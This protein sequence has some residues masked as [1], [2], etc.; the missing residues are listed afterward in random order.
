MK[1]NSIRSVVLAALA[2]TGLTMSSFAAGPGGDA[3][4]GEVTYETLGEALA[5]VQANQ[6]VVLQRDCT[7]TTPF[8]NANAGVTL[9]FNGNMVTYGGAGYAFVTTGEGAC[10]TISNGSF[11]AT[12]D[13]YFFRCEN[14]SQ[15]VL[16]G[17]TAD[18]KSDAS[19]I[20]SGYNLRNGLIANCTIGGTQA[21]SRNAVT[22]S[23]DK[24]FS[25][26]YNSVTI[27][28][29]KI[30]VPGTVEEPARWDWNDF[31]PSAA[32]MFGGVRLTITGDATEIRGPVH[33]IYA[34]YNGGE[35][36]IEGG[37]FSAAA[38]FYA[39][40]A[41]DHASN[42]KGWKQIKATITGGE[43]TGRIFT[44]D[45][46]SLNIE[47]G[48]F[49]SFQGWN[50][51]VYNG[52]KTKLSITGGTFDGDPN[53]FA[54]VD[55]GD[56]NKTALNPKPNPGSLNG[57]PLAMVAT[58]TNK[59]GVLTSDDPET[60]EIVEAA[61]VKAVAGANS[62]LTKLEVDGETIYDT[63]NPVDGRIYPYSE[64][65]MVVEGFVPV[66]M[67]VVVDTEMAATYTAGDG[68]HFGEWAGEDSETTQTKSGTA[69][70]DEILD[71]SGDAALL[72]PS[73]DD[74]TWIGA[75]GAKWGDFSSWDN[76]LVP[77]PTAT[78]HFT[79]SAVVDLNQDAKVNDITMAGG[80]E[81]TFMTAGD[82]K[83]TLTV[84]GQRY[85]DVYYYGWGTV[86]YVGS[87]VA[88]KISTASAN[89]ITV[90][91][92]YRA[93]D[94][95]KVTMT[96]VNPSDNKVAF[97]AEG[98][99]SEITLNS[100]KLP[101]DGADVTFAACDGGEV[102]LNGSSKWATGTIRCEVTNAFVFLGY[103][104]NGAKPVITVD[105][106][107]VQLGGVTAHAADGSITLCNGGDISLNGSC[108][109][110]NKTA[111]T[112]TSD[113][114]GAIVPDGSSVTL[115]LGAY[116][117]VNLKV[118]PDAT[119][120]LFQPKKAITVSDKATF[121]IDT[122]ALDNEAGDSWEIPLVDQG[123]VTTWTNF[124][125]PVLN[126]SGNYDLSIK[127][128]GAKAY[129]V[130][131]RPQPPTTYDW[132]RSNGKGYIKTGWKL[133]LDAVYTLEGQMVGVPAATQAIFA[134]EGAE[135]NGK[136][137]MLAFTKP[138]ISFYYQP[139]SDVSAEYSSTEA[140]TGIAD[141]KFQVRVEGNKATVNGTEL[142]SDKTVSPVTGATTGNL[143]FFVDVGNH[144]TSWFGDYKLYGMKIY[145]AAGS[146]LVCEFIPAK[147]GDS[148]GLIERQYGDDGVTV[149]QEFFRTPSAAGFEVGND[150]PAG[151]TVNGGA[152]IA[153]AG[154]GAWAVTPNGETTITVSGLKAGDKVT[155]PV[156][157]IESVAGV[158]AE[159]LILTVSGVE[160]DHQYF[161][162]VM[163]GSATFNTEL[164]EAAAPVIGEEGVE[165]PFVVGENAEVTIKAIS[166]LYYQ[167]LRGTEVT[168]IAEV[169][170]EKVLNGVFLTIT[171]T[172]GEKPETGAFYKVSVTKTPQK[173]DE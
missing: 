64:S 139:S 15:F 143:C 105:G 74:V 106:G 63:E 86:S 120:A 119:E 67:K 167:L 54:T 78:V 46:T 135:D 28:D 128:E 110:G 62:T 27:R 140:L 173:A 41:F 84:D 102:I 80:S 118:L 157:T 26:A 155:V 23:R 19:T 121:N 160:I 35:L 43:F 20:V 50:A 148:V 92:T 76:D 166:G 129:L 152:T 12:G 37:A 32:L 69:V 8:T 18:Q 52:S 70:V 161:V 30:F 153:A 137:F 10:L 162:G 131:A 21:R 25:E 75:E 104:F 3:V 122:T 65:G 100:F 158:P 98:D 149:T 44:Y 97:V 57:Q 9:D 40:L 146:K 17:V 169:V 60:W 150:E 145:D 107:E 99:E 31:Y 39:T 127:K 124:K 103:P 13:G 14:E 55:K 154:D 159:D 156:D 7:L 116:V 45:T 147:Q 125:T 38:N 59:V 91:G 101:T 151:P 134:S 138:Q 66:K 61:Q 16:D 96:T 2:A 81:L 73:A 72:P 108:A 48:T 126:A 113:G 68:Y 29:S 71:I 24:N 11:S 83:H 95:A 5:L 6:T 112:L 36:W 79:E 22:F 87:N 53:L 89:G 85:G 51:H 170:D 42:S 130:I 88:A 136:I 58:A 34:N 114:T 4:I 1:P 33:A 141:E 172:D 171:L 142:T 82:T 111:L 123:T 163:D 133:G 109:L 144:D 56:D 49:T 90:H 115:S 164:S 165:A 168:E 132:I 77:S 117:T 93:A 94:G 47:G